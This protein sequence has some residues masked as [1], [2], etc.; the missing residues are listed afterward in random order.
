MSTQLHRSSAASP[1]HSTVVGP[2][3]RLSALLG[4]RAAG[5]QAEMPS[6]QPDTGTTAANRHV[7]SDAVGPVAASPET[8]PS[9]LQ[10]KRK[11]GQPK[12]SAL[13]IF[14][15][16]RC[17]YPGQTCLPLTATTRASSYAGTYTWGLSSLSDQP[18]HIP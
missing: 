12:P 8:E 5:H 13:S 6:T 18:V 7:D 11:G 1:H 15:Y 9:A 16:I 10:I 4:R 14:R 17:P 3:Q 2:S